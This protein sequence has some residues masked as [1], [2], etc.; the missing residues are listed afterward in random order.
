MAKSNRERVGNVIDVLKSGLGPFVLREYKMFYKGQHYLDELRKVI[1]SGGYAPPSFGTEEEA[2]EMV[3]TQGWLNAISR[4]WMEIFNQKLGRSERAYVNELQDMRNDWAHQGA[5][6]NEE[7]R[8][9]ADT[10]TLLFKAINM[11]KHAEYTQKVVQVLQREQFA[12]EQK[13]S[14]KKPASPEGVPMT[15]QKGLRPWRAVIEPHPDVATGRYVQ[16]EF[17]A[18]LA[19]VHNNEAEPEYQDPLEFFRRTYLTEGLLTLLANGVKRLDGQGGD[20][21]VQLQTSFGGGK[22]HSMLALYHLFGGKIGIS[23]IPGGEQI[24]EKTGDIDDTIEAKRAVIVG[25]AFDANVPRSHGKIQTNTIW[26]DIAYQLGGAKGYKLMESADVSGV[27]PGSDSVRELLETH[28]PALII[29]DELVAFARMLYGAARTPAGDFDSV[30]TFMQTLTEG[31]R[32]SSDSLLLVSIPQSDIEVGGDGGKAALEIIS[33][34]IGRIESVWKP[35]SASESFEI[36]RRRLFNS[37]IDYAARDAVVSAF[38]KMYA[39]SK[40]DYPTGAADG[41]YLDRMKAAYPIHPE[42]FDRLYQDWSTLDSFQRTRGVLRFMAAVIHE[43]WIESD[44]SL[45]IMPASIPLDSSKVRDE[46]L[47]YLPGTWPAIVDADVDG[48]DSRPFLTDKEV[49]TLS[50]YAASRRVARSIFMGSAP[51]VAAQGVRG[52]ETVRINVATVQ[53]G[54]PVATFSD[55]LRRMSNQLM[56]LY[57]D[58]SRY[59]YDTRPTV[60]R[61]AQDKA[62]TVSADAVYAETN[63]RI[64]AVPV[65]KQHFAA[66]HLAPS[67]SA[68]VVDEWQARVV[69]LS[70]EQTHKRNAADSSAMQLAQQILE[71]RGT[72]PRLYRNMLVF[73]AADTTAAEALDDA[74]REYLAWKSI[75]DEQVE[76]NLDPQQQAQVQT[77]LARTDETVGTRMQEAY[78]WLLVPQQ[79]NPTGPVSME[80]H[81]ISGSD[82]FY[83]RGLRKLRQSE[84]LIHEWAPALLGMELDKHLWRDDPHVGVKQLWDY[85]ARYCYLPRLY[86]Q[87]VLVAAI[88][89]G[90][91]QSDAPFAYADLAKEDGSYQGLTL[92]S[93]TMIYFN[94]ESVLVR[95]KIAQEQFAREQ[96]AADAAAKAAAESAGEVYEQS[97][98]ASA[99]IA[100]GTTAGT[101]PAPE[102]ALMRR[103]YG[104]VSVDP[105]RVNR[106]VGTIVEEILERLTS[107]TGTDVTV[108]LE[109]AATRQ[110]GFDEGTVRTIRENSRTLKFGDSAFEES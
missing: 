7:A 30:M 103:Y 73:I 28:G 13:R 40:G 101:A 37:E 72:Q 31:V 95:P 82:N 80:A 61:L 12:A 100:E 65:D 19:Q 81:R 16:A 62:R 55:A 71:N 3:D 105:Q 47:R 52:V 97:G 8:R 56:Y 85:L 102:V 45:M 53:P 69:V 108:T 17:A 41:A 36:V 99:V 110:E 48:P 98:T 43:L 63:K 88:K 5:F 92:G 96:A 70:P 6:T 33:N 64:K 57:S 84:L 54:E 74:L 4:R 67:S 46:I 58:G 77:N 14:V 68:D 26:G 9:V 20:P 49:P 66:A 106:E 109:I 60:N 93:D 39:T 2:K 25:T 1:S 107:L 38:Q 79:P 34:T 83:D 50:K 78:S 89:Q 90:V 11:P 18:D 24:L 59:W 75:Q 42:L 104:S 94:D 22:T 51:S 44:Q 35:V 21:V 10:A 76:L 91:S 15:T 86:N 29:I 23:Q 32:R 87:D 27:A